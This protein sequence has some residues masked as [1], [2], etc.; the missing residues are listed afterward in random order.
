MHVMRSRTGISSHIARR[1]AGLSREVVSSTSSL[2]YL[3]LVI[4][5]HDTAVKYKA[6]G[7]YWKTMSY[8]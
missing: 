4:D 6:T 2:I 5:E 7:S 1:H 8:R 3:L